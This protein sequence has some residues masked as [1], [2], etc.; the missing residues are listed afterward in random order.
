MQLFSPLSI[1][2]FSS[3][4]SDSFAVWSSTADGSVK[5]LAL[6]LLWHYSIKIQEDT[7]QEDKNTRQLTLEIKK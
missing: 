1:Y 4:P 6:A 3:L 7:G 5:N 2:T